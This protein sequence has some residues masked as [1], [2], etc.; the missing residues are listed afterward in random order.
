MKGKYERLESLLRL[1]TGKVAD[2]RPD[3][4]EVLSVRDEW[5][6]SLTVTQHNGQQ[7]DH[8]INKLRDN[9]I[10]DEWKLKL[11]LKYHFK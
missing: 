4:S 2:E 10:S 7:Y 9:S 8:Y 5:T 3:C 1:M 6:Q 11:Y